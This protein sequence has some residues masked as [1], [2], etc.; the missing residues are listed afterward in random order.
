MTADPS[1]ESSPASQASAGSSAPATPGP[2][3]FFRLSRREAE[4]R[5]RAYSSADP[6]FR[7]YELGLASLRDGSQMAGAEAGR[8]TG[9]VLLRA[10]VRL[11]VCA[12]VLR[13]RRAL[14]D[15]PF[16]EIWG[17]AAKLPVF[18]RAKS[19][20]GDAV[21]AVEAAVVN[22]DG[23]RTL[24]MSS[25][26]ERDAL[27]VA[28]EVF[29]KHLAAP[30]EDDA[31]AVRRVGYARWTRVAV[32]G[33]I[34]V[35]AGISVLASLLKRPN[36]AL[37]A[38]VTLNDS[39]PN[40]NVDPA[41]VVDGDRSNLGFH[42]AQ[43]A[44]ATLT[45]DLGAVKSVHH[46]DIYNRSDCCQERAVPLEAEVSVDGSKYRSMAQMKYPFEFW[47]APL[48]GGTKARYVRLVHTSALYFHLAE[49]EVY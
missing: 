21:N 23:E 41:R 22:E 46:I 24:A 13:E 40:F 18:S 36:L 2:L 26:T 25:A 43:K 4:A 47:S 15:A 3:E 27:A 44:N 33:A 16:S 17:A 8:D 6:G 19:A 11:L 42:S 35:V 12:T 28:L 20:A 5:Q 10:A 29:G 32:A 34:L 38:G 37:H 9:L 7:E 14:G 45:I 48:P 39:D 1:S 31:T 30:L 49:V